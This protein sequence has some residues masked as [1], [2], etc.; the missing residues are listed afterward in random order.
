MNKYFLFSSHYHP[1]FRE[2]ARKIAHH[3][4]KVEFGSCEHPEYLKTVAQYVVAFDYT[5]DLLVHLG[6]ITDKQRLKSFTFTIFQKKSPRLAAVLVASYFKR[7]DE[8]RGIP[9]GLRRAVANDWA[10][11]CR[12][13]Q[14][15]HEPY[16]LKII[17]SRSGKIRQTWKFG[18]IRY[19][20][21]LLAS[22]I[23]LAQRTPP[24]Y[25]FF[26]PSD[27]P[28]VRSKGG[29]AG[30]AQAIGRGLMDGFRFWATM[31]IQNAYSSVSRDM[32]RK[33]FTMDQRI[34][35]YVVHPVLQDARSSYG[36][37][38][39]N[40]KASQSQL[41]QGSA[42]AWVIV[43]TLIGELLQRPPLGANYLRLVVFADNIAVG[44]HDLSSAIGALRAIEAKLSAEPSNQGTAAGKLILHQQQISDGFQRRDYSAPRILEEL[45]YHNSVDFCG[46]RI[47][48]DIPDGE[49][50]FA[51]SREAWLRFWTKV[52]R[53]FLNSEFDIEDFEAFRSLVLFRYEGWSKSFTLWRH[54]KES[55]ALVATLAAEKHDEIVRKRSRNS[56]NLYAH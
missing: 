16:E 22:W 27:D 1:R 30:A 8:E 5:Y 55:E 41:P 10:H 40:Q 47:R 26:A 49:V 45:T 17:R 50:K 18:I 37:K 38:H 42:H 23:M 39:A 54:Q 34:L 13:L 14:K 19:S 31:D 36:D 20:Q 2:W 46:Y 52:Q 15:T 6:S 25:D 4:A 28:F 43:S 11:A 48:L 9:K 56:K 12:L 53:E 7:G 35:R 24:G 33:L 29:H 32:V 3:H 21:Q 51:P 44:A